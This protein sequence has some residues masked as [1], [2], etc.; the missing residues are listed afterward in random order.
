MT[1]YRVIDMFGALPTAEA[2][3]Q[4][5]AGTATRAGDGYLDMYGGRMAGLFGMTEEQL[6]RTSR[7]MPHK[8]LSVLLTER[9]RSSE[10]PLDKF[11]AMLDEWGVEKT[12]ICI[13]DEGEISGM[14]ADNDGLAQLVRKYPDKL[15]GFAGENPHKGM[16]AV[17]DLERCVRGLGLK[18]LMLRPF[19]QEMRADDRRFYPL[20]TKAAELNIPVWIHTSIN[21]SY[22]I[23]IDYGRPIYLDHVACDFPELKLIIGHGGWPWVEEAMAIC[24][25]HPNVYIDFLS[26][27]PRYLT[28]PD[29]GWGSLVRYGNTIL[30]DKVLFASA[31]IMLGI[32]VDQVISEVAKLPLKEEVKEKWFYK[33]AAKLLG[34]DHG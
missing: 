10:I 2:I 29:T 23:T 21:F 31:W 25:K 17:R 12:V 16:A 30:Q 14:V 1:G 4:F 6:R 9:Y 5:V 3:G 32:P 26:V 8:E 22:T 33:N 24:W 13:A 27:L 34:L 28:A 15:I 7:E 20:Y 11:M 18:G 19:A